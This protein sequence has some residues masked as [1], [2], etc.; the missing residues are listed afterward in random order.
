[1]ALACLP[2][3]VAADGFFTLK[4]HGGPIM[5]IAV[6]ESGQIATASFDNSVG[7]WTGET[8]AWQEG[9]EA[10]VNTVHF[11]GPTLLSGGDDF[12]L[13]AWPGGEV[14]TQ[15]KGKVTDIASAGGM[16][17]TASW[18]GSIGL[19]EDGTIRFLTGHQAGVN[20]LAF[21]S[22]GRL[23]S[24]STDG[25]LRLWDLSS[26]EELRQLLSHGFGINEMV[27][28][29]DA[30]WIA[31]G[32]VDGV[33]RVIDAVTAEPI[34]DF[35]LERRPI[36]AMALS[37]DG[38]TLAV[39]DGEGYIMV[40]DTN[41]WRIAR[42]FRATL[43][44]P[45]WALAFSADGA[46]IHAGGLD[47]AMYS[48]PVASLNEHGQMSDAQ[49][50]F[51]RDPETM[52]NGE[53]QFERKCSICHTLTPSS[54][55]RAGPTLYGVF[56]RPAGTV[57]DYSYSETLKT[58]SII[59]DDTSIDD[60]FEEGPDHYIPGSKMPMQVIRDQQDRDDL[61]AYLKKATGE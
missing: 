17:A 24:A 6:S 46:N 18:D 7:L 2:L 16:I 14:L 59:W 5:G 19:W 47:T 23:I 57:S 3:P 36:L 9:H 1:M 44:G 54:A 30:G 40:I 55:R 35:T 43:R 50:S 27:F 49:Q 58:S 38:G 37:P 8:P 22:D 12:T 60:L 13:R 20:D 53:R 31:Y 42:D 28:N 61:I 48:W 29:E 52:E 11:A 25:T 45:V 4:G 39:G 10:A 33:T 56:G 15:H 26:G 51:L 21:T 41:E 34:A 32:A